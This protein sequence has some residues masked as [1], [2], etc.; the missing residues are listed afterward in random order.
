MPEDTP[1]SDNLEN[2]DPQ[3]G[4]NGGSLS[5]EGA[6]DAF[7]ALSQPTRLQVFRRLILEEPEGMRAGDLSRVLGIVPNTLS[8]H[9]S[10]LQKALL[11]R[12]RRQGREVHYR[13]RL[14][15]LRNLIHFLLDDCCQGNVAAVGQMLSEA[16][17]D[18]AGADSDPCLSSDI[19]SAVECRAED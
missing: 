5:T 14:D 7:A 13:V 12:S 16:L 3:A 11:I 4:G 15:T 9:L 8:F 18:S 6:L 17:G 2:R 1:I 19:L 10:A